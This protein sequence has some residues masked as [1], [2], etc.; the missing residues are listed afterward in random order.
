MRA[1][2]ACASSSCGLAKGERTAVAAGA[3]GAATTARSAALTRA[4]TGRGRVRAPESVPC[5]T[6]GCVSERVADGGE[7]PARLSCSPVALLVRL[8][9]GAAASTALIAEAGPGNGRRLVD[10]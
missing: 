10:R 7:R 1:T 4:W 2:V 8:R 9:A 5:N 6:R 3:T